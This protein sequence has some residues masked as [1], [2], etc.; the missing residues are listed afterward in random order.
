MAKIRWRASLFNRSLIIFTL[1]RTPLLWTLTMLCMR[2][3][4]QI[5]TT[6]LLQ[7][8]AVHQRAV[9][10]CRSTIIY[11]VDLVIFACLN[12]REVMILGLF[13]KFRIREFFFFFSSV[14]IIIIF[15]RFLNSRICP[16]REIREN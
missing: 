12:F 1:L 6:H 9:L 15:A 10:D 16:S 4:P 3:G 14:I 13:T 5:M 11:T 8:I 2:A 7:F